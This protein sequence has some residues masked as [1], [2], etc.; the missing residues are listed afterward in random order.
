MIALIIH[1]HLQLI[2]WLL[3]HTI[4]CFVILNDTPVGE[5]SKT[6]RWSPYVGVTS[7]SSMLVITKSAD[8]VKIKCTSQLIKSMSEFLQ[9][10]LKYF[11][12]TSVSTSLFCNNFI[13]III[14][15]VNFITF[16]IGTFF[17]N[18]INT[19]SNNACFVFKRF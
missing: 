17:S 6:A 8:Q 9:K 19:T 1:C 2:K 15:I 11:N 5:L 7:L 14:R 4:L 16:R 3:V 18:I 12:G 13:C 10:L